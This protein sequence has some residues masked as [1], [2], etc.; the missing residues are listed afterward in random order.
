MA[1]PLVEKKN[2]RPLLTVMPDFGR[3]FI[4]FYSE[5]DEREVMCCDA[6][7][8][9]RCDNHPMSDA[10]FDAFSEWTDEFESA[11]PVKEAPSEQSKYSDSP[12]L[13]LNWPDFHERGLELAKR[14]KQEVG[15]AFRVVYTKPPED[16]A[17]RLD[18]CREILD[19]GSVASLRSSR[20]QF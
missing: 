15:A 2:S 8:L 19:D 17:Y 9:G 7:L 11:P 4:W 16:P 13:D 1:P 10:L 3:A 20:R 6:G 12:Y 14:L 5:G 18:E